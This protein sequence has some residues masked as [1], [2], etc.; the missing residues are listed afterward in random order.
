[1]LGHSEGGVVAPMV[2]DEEPGIGFVVMLAGTGVN[3]ARVSLSQRRAIMMADGAS[4]EEIEADQALTGKL[5]DCYPPNT[6]ATLGDTDP[7]ETCMRS[8][9]E[10]AGASAEDEDA[11]V[12]ELLTP[13]NQF[14]MTYDP[15]PVLRRVRAP[16]LALNGSL[17]LQVLASENLPVIRALLLQAGNPYSTTVELPG[18]N[19]LF[20]HA[21][22][23]SPSEYGRIS[24]TMAPELLSRVAR[25]IEDLPHSTKH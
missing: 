15:A 24:E 11:T 14:F 2:A 4:E 17:D 13:W 18:L 20:Q 8:A 19:H 23:G 1:V 3:G 9:L 7:T 21:T 12:S 25:W 22:T 6:S 16:V 10:Q 5:L